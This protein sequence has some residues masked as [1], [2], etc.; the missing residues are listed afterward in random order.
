[1]STNL[2]EPK[3]YKEQVTKVNAAFRKVRKTNASLFE[4]VHNAYDL[5]A[6]DW[7]KDWARF[8]L[9][10]DCDTS[11]FNKIV[12]IVK[13]EFVMSNIDQLPV[14]W[15][16]LYGIALQTKDHLGMLQVALD[17]GELNNRT[18][19]KELNALISVETTSVRPIESIFRF[20]SSAY[21]N[22]ELEELLEISR[23]LKE[24]FGITVRDL[25]EVTGDE[26][27]DVCD[28]APCVCSEE[29]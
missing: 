19:L 26:T 29:K 4:S 15:S 16:V 11:T 25:A 20:D 17:N 8:K 7:K 10:V 23:V 3:L 6:T 18:T 27:C 5:L 22:E 12:K 21:S 28:T 1:M 13:T 24:K 9:D 14:A 2:I